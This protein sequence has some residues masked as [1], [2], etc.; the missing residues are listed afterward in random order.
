MRDFNDNSIEKFVTKSLE[1]FQTPDELR[2]FRQDHSTF[3]SFLRGR[4]GDRHLR[5]EACFIVKHASWKASHILNVAKV[6]LLNFISCIF[7]IMNIIEIKL[8][9]EFLNNK[10][11][12]P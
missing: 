5:E 1:Y 8:I 7:S 3:L 9:S 12:P 11:M 10:Y 2:S 4:G 6:N